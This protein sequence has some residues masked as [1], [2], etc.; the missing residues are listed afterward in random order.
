MIDEAHYCKNAGAKR[1]Q[2]AQRLAAASRATGSC[3]R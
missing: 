2:A 3:W 1:T